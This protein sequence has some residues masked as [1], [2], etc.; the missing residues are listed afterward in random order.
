MAFWL[1]VLVVVVVVVAFAV[2]YYLSLKRVFWNQKDN[3][4]VTVIYL[5]RGIEGW[6]TVVHGGALATVIDENLGRV[7]IRHFPQ[8]TGVTANL[9][10]NYRRP[11]YSDQFYSLHTSLDRERS[12]D[13][14]AYVKTELRDITG[15]LCT[16][17]SGLFVVPKKL[18]LAKLGENF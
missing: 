13:R 10:I 2:A 3:N 14:K 16:E 7:A 15:V 18:K 6:P 5:G 12:T 4:T 11:V 9:D 17:A 8:K 1:L